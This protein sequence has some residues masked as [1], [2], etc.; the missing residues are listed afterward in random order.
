MAANIK[1][2]KILNGEEIIADVTSETSDTIIIKNPVRI[3]VMPQPPQM[4]ATQ[5]K[6]G[7]A[8][9]AEFADDKAIILN[10]TH[11]LAMM[12]PIKEFINQYNTIFGGIVT[13]PSGLILP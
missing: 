1:L 9:W 6:I 2:I 4:Q 11:I 3:V 7:L 12:N 8:P 13:A 5:P 10:K